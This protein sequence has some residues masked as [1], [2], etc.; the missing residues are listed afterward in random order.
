[1]GAAAPFIMAGI[2]AAGAVK[3]YMDQQSAADAQRDAAKRKL[4]LDD[5]NAML[6]KREANKRIELTKKKQAELEATNRARAGASGF[7]N[8]GSIRLVEE[9]VMEE[10]GDQIN[11]LES[12]K[13]SRYNLAKMG[14]ASDYSAGMSQ[15]DATDAGSYQSLLSGFSSVYSIGDDKNWWA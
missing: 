15:A 6:G 8:T 12:A 7:S 1:M 3:G 13:D 11:W 5:M 9:G 14:A 4:L 2:S 10:H